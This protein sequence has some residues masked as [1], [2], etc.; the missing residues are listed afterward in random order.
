MDARSIQG[1]CRGPFLWREIIREQ[2]MGWWRGASFADP[3]T[4]AGQGQISKPTRQTGSRSHNTPNDEAD[5]NETASDPA[6]RQPRQGKTCE[7][8]KY[9]E[10][11]AGEE[12]ESGVG[13]LEIFFDRLEE[14]RQDLTVN[15]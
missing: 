8:I 4:N 3:Y 7:G 2:R 15:K 10:S 14:D 9:S 12:S 13:D 5:G 6:I 11:R 1:N